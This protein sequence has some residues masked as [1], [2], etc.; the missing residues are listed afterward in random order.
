MAPEWPRNALGS[1]LGSAS[2]RRGGEHAH[3]AQ[4]IA[5]IARNGDAQYSCTLVDRV[6]LF[7]DVSR[8]MRRLVFEA[9]NYAVTFASSI[10][11]ATWC[12]SLSSTFASLSSRLIAPYHASASHSRQVVRA[13]PLA[14]WKRLLEE[15]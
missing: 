12:S 15:L 13:V 6:R 8:E 4:P 5:P 2:P 3:R 10:L 9:Q 1:A 14:Y 11:S 7:R